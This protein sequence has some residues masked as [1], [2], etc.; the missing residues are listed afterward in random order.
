MHPSRPSDAL[1]SRLWRGI[2]GLAAVLVMF[3]SVSSVSPE[4]HAWL[5]EGNSPH[6]GHD[7]PHHKASHEAGTP[8]SGAADSEGQGRQHECAVTLFA[9]GVVHHAAALVTQPCEGILRAV[10]Y[11]AFERLALAQPRF[12]HLP[13]Q[14]P[15]AV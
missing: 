8:L 14:A 11:R 5:H 15:P 6:A 7:C 4:L 2:A 10:N 12:L 1:P 13:P 3:M 9:R